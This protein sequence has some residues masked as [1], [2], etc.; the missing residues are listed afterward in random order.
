MLQSEL[1]LIDHYLNEGGRMFALFN[2]TTTN[3]DLGLEKVLAK[4]GVNVSSHVVV[5]PMFTTSDPPGSD[6]LAFF[7]SGHPAVNPLTGSKIQLIMPRMIS[8]AELPSPAA[9]G[10]KAEEI[11]F[12][13]PKAYLVNASGQQVTNQ[14]LAVA[15][16]TSVARERGTTRILVVGDSIFLDNK[17][18]GLGANRQFV[19]FAVDWLVQRDFKL[20]GVGPKPVTEYRLLVTVSQMRAAQWLLLAAVPGGVLLFGGLVWL[21]R[22]K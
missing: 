8:R 12:T 5:D 11:I 6:V 10:R 9:D 7:F 14:P 20:Q 3:L 22:R 2:Y 21:R 15:V 13:G 1:D 17:L 19:T 16:E 18:I 4:W